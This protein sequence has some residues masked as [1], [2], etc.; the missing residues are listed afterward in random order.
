M[1]AISAAIFFVG[2]SPN[3]LKPK[4]ANAKPIEQTVVYH[5]AVP[6]AHQPVPSVPVVQEDP[7]PENVEPK[8]HPFN[9]RTL[10]IVGQMVKRGKT[11]YEFAVAQNAQRVASI[12][13]DD[14]EQLGYT[15]KAGVPCAAQI[16]Y[17]KWTSWVIC[18]APQLSVGMIAQGQGANAE[19]SQK[20]SEPKPQSKG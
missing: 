13:G 15:I 14:L 20:N 1:F 12:S 11:I 6:A 2:G 19:P 7:E 9:G 4:L 5:D 18:D 17:D 10:H 3:L 16:T 8:G